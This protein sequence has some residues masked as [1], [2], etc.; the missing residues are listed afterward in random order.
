MTFEFTLRIGCPVA[1]LKYCPQ[2]IITQRYEGPKE[3]DFE[4]FKKFLSTIPESETIIFSG[5]SEPFSNSEC[6]RM[7]KYAHAKGHKI[8]LFTTLVGLQP[9]TAEWLTKTIPFDRL[10]LHLP[11]ASGNARIPITPDYL[12]TLGLVLENV[13]RIEYMN[14]GGLFATNRTDEFVRGIGGFPKKHGYIWCRFLDSPQYNIL[15][16]GDVYTCC[17][18]QRFISGQTG[19]AGVIGN[20]HRD[21]YPELAA[22]FNSIKFDLEFN[23]NSICHTCPASEVWWKHAALNF[24]LGKK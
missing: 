8:W 1:C 23:G 9:I 24:R 15:P 16:N 22:K 17:V 10:C 11:D 3:L 18:T 6:P 21:T 7:I 5:L 20:L 4:T 12:K 19:N 14:M 2:E 13:S